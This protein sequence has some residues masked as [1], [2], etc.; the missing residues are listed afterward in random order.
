MLW[1]LKAST[2]PGS[3]KSP[4]VPE[5]F[6][7]NTLQLVKFHLSR[8]KWK[9]KEW[10]LLYLPIS[11]TRVFRM[12]DQFI[13]RRNSDKL[14]QFLSLVLAT[15]TRRRENV[16]R[17]RNTRGAH[18]HDLDSFAVRLMRVWE[19]QSRRH[20]S[21]TLCTRRGLQVVTDS[22]FLFIT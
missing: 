12:Y 15:V 1:N 6:N 17:F 19:I 5:Y 7:L 14:A 21:V 10:R 9:R 8:V 20:C 18:R 3:Q 4:L 11:F 13:T 2:T 16:R 22:V